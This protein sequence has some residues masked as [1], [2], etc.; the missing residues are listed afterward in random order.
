MSKRGAPSDRKSP[1]SIKKRK[2]I[3]CIDLTQSPIELDDKDGH[4]I[5]K[6]NTYLNRQC[7][8]LMIHFIDKIVKLLGQGTFGKVVEAFDTL[9][10]KRVAIKI[11]K[12]IQKYRDASKMEIKILQTLR[13]YDPFNLK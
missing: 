7:T 9:S 2:E 6:T 3:E 4:L 12:S 11:I 1:V 13:Q 8:S 10:Q 5:I